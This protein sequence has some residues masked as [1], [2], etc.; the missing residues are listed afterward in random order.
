MFLLQS[1]YMVAKDHGWLKLT[2]RPQEV[3]R[4]HRLVSKRY[5]KKKMFGDGS[6]RVSAHRII[7]AASLSPVKKPTSVEKMSKL[8]CLTLRGVR[9]FGPDDEQKLDFETPITLIQGQNGCGKTTIIEALKYVTAGEFPPGTTKGQGFIHDPK[10]T[11]KVSVKGQVRLA[12]RDV[13]GQ[14]MAVVRTIE[15]IQKKAKLEMKTLDSTIIKKTPT[16]EQVSLS[17]KCADLDVE[18]G[19]ALGVTKPILN[20]VLFCHQEESNWPLDEPKKLKEKFDAIFSATKY[21]KC[22]DAIRNTRKKYMEDVKTSKEVLKELEKM[23]DVLMQKQNELSK[24]QKR[25]EE[26][27]DEIET[28]EVQL[29]PLREKLA[30]IEKEEKE[31]QQLNHEIDTKEVKL[32]ENERVQKDLQNSISEVFRGTKEDLE[33]DI[34]AFALKIREKESHLKQLEKR[35]E[36]IGADIERLN[37]ERR[38]MLMEVGRL[39]TEH[40]QHNQSIKDRDTLIRSAARDF[41]IPAEG[42]DIPQN[43]MEKF[44][45]DLN[46]VVTSSEDTMH[47]TEA[48]Y[49][50]KLNEAQERISE[51]RDKRSTL[52]STLALKQQQV[53]ESKEE[54]RKL[55]RNL[56]QMSASD[57]E[58]SIKE[59]QIER[60]DQDI[61]ALEE[62]FDEGGIKKEIEEVQG[63]KSSLETVVNQLN[64]E[65]NRLHIESSARAELDK[66]RSDL[67]AKQ[68]SIRRLKVTHEDSILHLVGNVADEDIRSQVDSLV[69]RLSGEVKTLQNQLE[70]ARLENHRLQDKKVHCEKELAAKEKEL[71]TSQTR[72][73]DQVGNQELE[74]AIQQTEKALTENQE[75]KGALVG[76]THLYSRYVKRLQTKG[77]DCP[78]CHRKFESRTQIE[79]LK[80]HIQDKNTAVTDLEERLETLQT[81]EAIARS[82]QPDLALLETQVRDIQRLKIEIASQETR[83]SVS[84]SRRTLQVVAAEKEREEARLSARRMELESLQQR[85]ADHRERL[86]DLRIQKSALAEAKI[87]AVNE[88]QER[89]KMEEKQGELQKQIAKTEAEIQEIQRKCEPLNAQLNASSKDKARIADEKRVALE[90]HRTNL[91]KKRQC[92]DGIESLQ[93]KIMGYE[94]SGKGN[95]LSEAQERDD[96]LKTE[97]AQLEARRDL[98]VEQLDSLRRDI[99]QQQVRENELHACLLLMERQEEQAELEKQLGRLRAQVSGHNSTDLFKEKQT[100]STRAGTLQQQVQFPSLPF[101]CPVSRYQKQGQQKELAETIC[102]INKELQGKILRD[103]SANYLKKFQELKATEIVAEDLNKYYKALDW[104]IMRFH[105]EKMTTIN[106]TVRELWSTT[107]KGSD[108]DYIE[109]KTDPSDSKGADSR[110]TYNYRVVMIKNKVELDMRGRCSAGQKVLASLI[111]RI[112]LAETFGTKCGVLALDEPT[113][114]LDKENVESLAEALEELVKKRSRQRN[115][116]LVVISHDEAF[117]ERLA[118]KVHVDDYYHVCRD[119]NLMGTVKVREMQTCYKEDPS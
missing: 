65:L 13:N 57:T 106:R 18:V 84:D 69:Q 34:K 49:D 74:T 99:S 61:A 16:G 80:H 35:K 29:T 108:I 42:A 111:I 3:I 24:L 19:L 96:E 66:L 37:G 77:P 44:L 82:I 118:T 15:C 46:G 56:N 70:A 90:H 52:D 22:L 50:M 7:T 101:F 51:I 100:L 109:I 14:S 97:L 43:I 26:T 85:L 81:D 20:Y 113:T 54:V 36:S 27:R 107:Y 60:V 86:N 87:K 45:R 79:E 10:L 104:A 48:E 117:V 71:Q 67:N 63:Q 119:N 98:M 31:I 59:S 32:K 6:N 21:I 68:E 28:I 23:Q 30:D 94:S 88:L 75:A 105:V 114:N 112:A 92:R 89:V 102:R 25:E 58:L 1:S 73:Q 95:R 4:I 17:H 64:K 93:K 53:K 78:L 9:N 33:D 11:H 5:V 103:A 91:E 83:V 8:K 116:Q 76:S 110:R 62:A 47:M 115:F 40:D 55:G 72:I 41:R 38:K 12:F 2:C 39:Q